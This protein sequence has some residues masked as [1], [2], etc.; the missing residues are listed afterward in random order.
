M[1]AALLLAAGAGRS[2]AQGAPPVATPFVVTGT[3]TTAAGE[4]LAGIEVFADNTL[5]YDSNILGTTDAAGRYRIELPA[6]VPGTWNVGGYIRSTYHGVPFDL[7]LH[8][9][10]DLPVVASEGGVRDLEWRLTGPVP[11][12]DSFYGEDVWVYEYGFAGELWIDD[13]ELTFTPLEPLIDGS[14]IEPFTRRPVGSVIV[15]V[16]LGYYRVTARSVP[17]G[18]P[19]ADLLITVRFGD[20]PTTSVD[21]AFK[22]SVSYGTI[23]ELEVGLP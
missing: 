21:V 6:D 10:L 14:V 20:A 7:R 17:E 22:D 9:L 19:Q 8:P 23:M 13:V 11:E 1:V 16:P 12:G 5:F 2:A 4:P 18:E 3:V 15:D